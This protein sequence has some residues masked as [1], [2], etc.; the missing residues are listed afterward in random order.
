LTARAPAPTS[1]C[2]KWS[3]LHEETRVID[4]SSLPTMSVGEVLEIASL[5]ANEVVGYP[6]TNPKVLARAVRELEA[7]EEHRHNAADI[8]SWAQG[9]GEELQPA[10]PGCG[11]PTAQLRGPQRHR[12]V[13]PSTMNPRRA[14]HPRHVNIALSSPVS[15]R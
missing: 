11:E 3:R 1:P 8:R 4:L 15:E 2:S 14:P 10:G 7:H 9:L 13:S 12:H 5:C 6:P